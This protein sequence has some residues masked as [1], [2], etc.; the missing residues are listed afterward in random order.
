MKHKL[1]FSVVLKVLR[2]T[3]FLKYLIKKLLASKL[4]ILE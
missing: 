2:F 1:V 4:V 3:F